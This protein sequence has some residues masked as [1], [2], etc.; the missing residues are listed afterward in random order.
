MSSTID[1]RLNNASG[2]KVAEHLLR[3]DEYFL[4]PLSERVEITAYAQK[5]VSKA[6]R[7]EAWSGDTMVGLVAIYCNDMETRIAH[8]TSV[9]VLHEWMNKGIAARLMEQCIAYAQAYGVHTIK[10]EVASDNAPA[11]CLYAKHGFIVGESHTDLTIMYLH[12]R[13]GG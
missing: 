2:S 10:L 4:P 7:F 13:N 12:L 6:A 11:I 5:L 9:S 8:I 1:Y 3:C